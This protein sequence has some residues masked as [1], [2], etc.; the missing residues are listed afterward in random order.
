[1]ATL[2]MGL[3]HCRERV[4]AANP[5]W[6]ENIV[7]HFDRCRENDLAVSFSAIAPPRIFSSHSSLARKP[8]T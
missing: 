4:A 2:I 1:M 8:S 6:A 5:E 7:N 3:Y